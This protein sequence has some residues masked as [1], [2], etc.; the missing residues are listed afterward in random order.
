M[1]VALFSFL[2]SSVTTTDSQTHTDSTAV[3]RIIPYHRAMH[4]ID[5]GTAALPL[6]LRRTH[7]ESDVTHSVC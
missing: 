3:Y 5:L 2:C 6:V 7:I 1:S 4:F